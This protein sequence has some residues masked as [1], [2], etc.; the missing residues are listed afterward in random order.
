MEA[1]RNGSFAIIAISGYQP[2]VIDGSGCGSARRRGAVTYD[3]A[4]R[5]AQAQTPVTFDGGSGNRDGSPKPT[6]LDVVEQC[7]VAFFALDGNAR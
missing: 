2:R 5:P 1:E 6:C 3:S 7:P 4:A